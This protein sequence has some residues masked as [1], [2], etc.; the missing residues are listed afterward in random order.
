[1][2]ELEE[3]G[4]VEERGGKERERWQKQEVRRE[5]RKGLKGMA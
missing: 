1:M 3:A 4:A 5:E 2:R